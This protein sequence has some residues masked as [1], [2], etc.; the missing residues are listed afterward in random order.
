MA[1][2]EFYY[3]SKEAWDSYK[4][5]AA[6]NMRWRARLRR[7]RDPPPEVQGLLPENASNIIKPFIDRVVH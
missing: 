3:D 4:Y 1:D 5:D 2:A 7:Y 6:W